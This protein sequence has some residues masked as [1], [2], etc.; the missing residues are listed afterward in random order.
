MLTQMIEKKEDKVGESKLSQLFIQELFCTNDLELLKKLD[1]YENTNKELFW[2]PSWFKKIKNSIQLLKDDKSII[3]PD[4]RAFILKCANESIYSFAEHLVSI[5]ILRDR[6]FLTTPE[7][8]IKLIANAKDLDNCLNFL[9]DKK[10]NQSQKTPLLTP[11][12]REALIEN[13]KDAGTIYVGFCNLKYHSAALVTPENC[14]FLIRHPKQADDLPA[15]ID[16]LNRNSLSTSE[17]RILLDQHAKHASALR[18]V[19]E[20]SRHYYFV[21]NPEV[22]KFLIRNAVY[23]KDIASVGELLHYNGS[24][25]ENLELRAL[26]EQ[27]AED[28]SLIAKGI[29]ILH[30]HGDRDLVTFENCKMLMENPKSAE[31]TAWGLVIVK[32]EKILEQYRKNFVN[33]YEKM[34]SLSINEESQKSHEKKEEVKERKEEFKEDSL[35]KEAGRKKTGSISSQNIFEGGRSQSPKPSSESLSVEPSLPKPLPQAL[36]TSL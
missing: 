3:R 14:N 34:N 32:Q 25:F 15:I 11:E 28:A 2:Y 31:C 22:C 18:S 4:I 13:A 20:S 23:A 12:V 33:T 19:L 1:H 30:D 21:A 36:K 35:F 27:H 7:H 26:L 5:K 29:K 10:N 8:C 9:E 16:R 6:G 24:L 17:I